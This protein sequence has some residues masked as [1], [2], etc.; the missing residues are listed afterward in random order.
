MTKNT[1]N[2]FAVESLLKLHL[3]HYS[4]DTQVPCLSSLHSTPSAFNVH[5]QFADAE[6]PSQEHAMPTIQDLGVLPVDLAA[7]SDGI[8]GLLGCVQDFAMVTSRS[9]TVPSGDVSVT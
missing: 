5:W 4:L 1:G 9:L 7:Y 3:S 2:L 8:N 6:F